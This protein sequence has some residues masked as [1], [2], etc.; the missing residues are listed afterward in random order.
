MQTNITANR[1]YTNQKKQQAASGKE[2]CLHTQKQEHKAN[3]LICKKNVFTAYIQQ[4]T[5]WCVFTPTIA[6]QPEAFAS[7]VLLAKRLA[8]GFLFF[9]LLLTSNNVSLTFGTEEE[10][11]GYVYHTK[12]VAF[13]LSP[14]FY[15]SFHSSSSLFR[16]CILLF[17]FVQL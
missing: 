1:I 8:F 6:S 15:S 7:L 5:Q 10:V 13:K 12:R 9:C 14:L 11:C 17:A 4:H 2:M 16:C 3:A